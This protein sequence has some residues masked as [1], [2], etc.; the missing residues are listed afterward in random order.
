MSEKTT[1]HRSIYS[2]TR[3]ATN[4]D[5][6]KVFLTL[7]VRSRLP[8]SASVNEAPVSSLSSPRPTS[9]K[10]PQC[11]Y[12]GGTGGRVGTSIGLVVGT[13]VGLELGRLSRNTSVTPAPPQVILVS[14]G[15]FMLQS[16]DEMAVAKAV[17]EYPQKHCWQVKKP[18]RPSEDN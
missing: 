9:S 11:V 7:I 6:R 18:M 13:I 4:R 8:S 16:L 15:Q 1:Q 2:T 5:A 17:K 10:H 14:P 3:C 12:V